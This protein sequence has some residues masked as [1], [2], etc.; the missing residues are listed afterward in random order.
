M[1]YMTTP[2]RPRRRSQPVRYQPLPA[3]APEVIKGSG[4]TAPHGEPGDLFKMGDRYVS[5][6]FLM[7]T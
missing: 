7:S 5:W 6:E 4:N 2:S 1:R 3:D